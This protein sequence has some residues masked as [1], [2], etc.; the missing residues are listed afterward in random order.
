MRDAR[1]NLMRGRISRSGFS[2][3]VFL[4]SASDPWPLPFLAASVHQIEKD[5]IRAAAKVAKKADCRLASVVPCN[6]RAKIDILYTI[7]SASS[8]HRLRVTRAAI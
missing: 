7:W 6:F 1:C 4:A 5:R 8:R 3:R 2:L